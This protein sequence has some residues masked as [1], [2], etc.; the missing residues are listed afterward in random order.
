MTMKTA[1]VAAGV[2]FGICAAVSA[3]SGVTFVG[4][5]KV[6]EAIAKGGGLASG[7]TYRVSG[8]HRMGPGEVEVHDKETDIFYVVEGEATVVTGGTM[9]GGRQ[10]AAGQHRGTDVTGGE[11]R[12]LQKGDVMVIPAGTPHWFKDVSPIVNYLTIKVVKP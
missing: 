8:N 11:T 2:F 4:H 9:V 12:K 5:E 1:L 7:A 10:T 3:Q 6:A